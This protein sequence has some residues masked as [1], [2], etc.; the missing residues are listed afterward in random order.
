MLDMR[1]AA[2]LGAAGRV[3]AV[4]AL[5]L[6]AGAAAVPTPAVAAGA[7]AVYVSPTGVDTNPGTQAQPVQSLQRAQQL[8]RGMN[9]AM[10]SDVTV[11]LEDGYYRLAR[12]LTLDAS[13]SGTGGHNVVWTADS[14]ARPVVA[15]STRLTGWSPVGTTGIW[16]AQGPAG[17]RTRQLYV[18]GARAERAGGSSPVGL[19]RTTT[20]YTA[21]SA[22][23]AGWRDPSGQMPPEI[24]F[25]YPR[26]LGVWTEP[27]CPLG[28]MSG[29]RITMAQPC[30]DNSTKRGTNHVGPG[31]LSRG[32]ARVENAFQLLTRPGQWYLDTASGKFY[33][34]PRPGQ[35]MSTVD[36]EAPV[37]ESLVTGGGTAGSPLHNV[38]FNGIQFSYATWM[39]ASSSSGFSEVQ[40]NYL[41]QG[42][43]PT[44][45]N[46]RYIWF[47][48]PANVSL[49]F[50]QN[51]QFT[52]DAFIHLGGAGLGLGNGSQSD[53]VKGNVVTDTSGSGIQL[54][55]V[56][57]PGA[58]G[59]V[60][61]LNNVIQ[62][63]YVHHTVAEYHGGIGVDVGY[64]AGT[65]LDHNQIDDLPY[66][67]VSMGWGGWNDK[68]RRPGIA[69]F[70]RGNVVSNNLI[71]N[72][73]TVLSDGAAVYSNGPTGSSFATGEKITGNVLH[74][75]PAF[76]HVINTDNGTDWM[77]VTGN[78]IWNTGKGDNSW[79]YCHTDY[80]PGEG[81]GLDHENVSGNYW[82]NRFGNG[83]HGQL[84][85]HTGNCS[86]QGN[87]NITGPSQVPASILSNAGLEPA[88]RGLLTWTQVPPPH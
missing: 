49:T 12:P 20:G 29:T 57:Q 35:D 60:Q 73:V 16:A 88:F 23:M 84:P 67:G 25:V 38:V 10:T 13:D 32:P 40:A 36:V 18:D 72:I 42:S 22:L 55:N 87:T 46:A 48:T 15:G 74:D 30:W 19:T 45:G 83:S 39:G 2:G 61:T 77:T 56:D 24:E 37:L 75:Q 52:N 63:N 43:S 76:A 14:G 78:A 51:V 69:N 21:S 71:F 80:Y 64:A 85:A 41:N 58:T 11:F 26:G 81:G 34:M 44:A 79:G 4:A 7:N 31:N 17:V 54:G 66:S 50:D 86:V 6:I 27:R 59:S 62:D 47:Q 68:V 70:S 1:R 53:V 5:A 9:Q 8:V 82:D 28:S 33:Y 3:A 65:L